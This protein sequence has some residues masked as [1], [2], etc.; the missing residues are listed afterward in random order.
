MPILEL[1]M[2]IA[3]VNSADTLHKLASEVF[4]KVVRGELENAAIPCSAYMEYELA[5]RSRGYDEEEIRLDLESFR[6][7]RNLGEV[8]LTPEILL[9]ASRLRSRYR[10]SYFDSLHAASALAH[11]KVIIS[12]DKAYQK[13][14]GLR[15]VDPRKGRLTL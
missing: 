9:E 5:L 12:V 3:F 14:P 11:D 13:I 4:D 10:L 6:S 7:M 8:P 2:M 15:I 1:D